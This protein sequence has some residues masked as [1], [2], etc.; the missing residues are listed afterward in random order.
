MQ[1]E[2]T[3]ELAALLKNAWLRQNPAVLEDAVSKFKAAIEKR[4]S[5]WRGSEQHDAQ[6]F[7]MW[8]LDR[9]HEDLNQAASAKYK[10]LKVLNF[11]MIYLVYNNFEC[12]GGSNLTFSR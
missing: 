9:L 11:K 6:E 10:P 12:F 4:A 3:E 2:V 5:Q 8:L 1:C 7:F